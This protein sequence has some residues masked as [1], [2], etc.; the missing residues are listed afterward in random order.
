MV[1]GERKPFDEITGMLEGHKKI[2]V[3]GC[4]GCVTV[5][6][7]GGQDEV[8]VLSSQLRMARDN[9]GNPIEIVEKTVER[10]CDPE[11]V[12][13]V[14]EIVPEVD[15]V[16]S[17]ACGAGVQYVA[18]RYPGMPVYPALD[19]SFVGGST[20]EGY[21]VEKCQTCGAC[22]L[23]YTGGI[24]PIARCSKSLLNGPCGGSTKGKCEID[25]EVDCGWQLILDRLKSLNRM[26]LYEQNMAVC[27]WRTNRDGGPRKMVREDFQR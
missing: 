22:K 6:L 24:C 27:D 15:A 12:E 10:Q 18:E 20:K 19:T 2:M 14:R 26:D 16:L 13:E 5:C 9:A 21:Y 8:R 3:L 11:Y 7:T 25:S 1:V 17:M 23:F 4:G